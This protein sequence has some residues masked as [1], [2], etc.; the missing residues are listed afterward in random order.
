MINKILSEDNKYKLISNEEVISNH[1]LNISFLILI[2]DRA[3]V[4]KK[5]FANRDKLITNPERF[6]SAFYIQNN[7]NMKYIWDY[8][9]YDNGW[10]EFS[11]G[12]WKSLELSSLLLEEAK[13]YFDWFKTDEC[14][15][16]CEK[17]KVLEFYR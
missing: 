1:D 14:L 16:Y 5:S 8:V 11:S 15:F 13:L 10:R 2:L 7:S 6:F 9:A 17:L 4:L 3:D 12:S